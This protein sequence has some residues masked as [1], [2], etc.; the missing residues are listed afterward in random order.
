MSNANIDDIVEEE[1]R[2]TQTTI[3]NLKR[4][5]FVT[6]QEDIVVEYIYE[7]CIRLLEYSKNRH[8]SKEVAYAINLNT[9]S[10]LL[11]ILLS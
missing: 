5:K 10:F 3:N 1:S 4:P 7:Y 2:I 9:L 6:I 8:G 11:Q